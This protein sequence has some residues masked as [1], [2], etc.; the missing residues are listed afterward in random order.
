MAVE[1]PA[2]S[3]TVSWDCYRSAVNAHMH[4]YMYMQMI[5]VLAVYVQMS[6]ADFWGPSQSKHIGPSG[7]PAG[8]LAVGTWLVPWL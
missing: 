2:H 6:Y 4:G 5:R 1:F 7:Q 8:C 3:N